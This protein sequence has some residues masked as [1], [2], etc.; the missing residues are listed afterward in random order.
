[1]KKTDQM[2]VQINILKNLSTGSYVSRL[3]KN[4]NRN[5]E[6]FLRAV[7]GQVTENN[8][9]YSLC[10]VSAEEIASLLG[11]G[12]QQACMEIPSICEDILN[13]PLRLLPGDGTGE[14]TA[15]I[16]W[17]SLIYYSTGKNA[18]IW[19]KLNGDMGGYMPG[20]EDCCRQYP[21]NGNDFVKPENGMT[22]TAGISRSYRIKPG[23]ISEYNQNNS[24]IS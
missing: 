15:G 3:Y 14:G 21:Y 9:A 12:I 24:K 23:I 18:G 5:S 20:Y 6:K 7:I 16:P 11:T 10:F 4:L 1:M 13:N 22:G 2:T 17:V 19:I 8:M